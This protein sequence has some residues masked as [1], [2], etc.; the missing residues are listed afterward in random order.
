MESQ[1]ISLNVHPQI[2]DLYEVL[3]KN[4]LHKQKEDVQSLVGY[5]ESMEYNLSV[6]MNEIQE[7]HAEVK[8]LHDRGIR[9]QCG[10]IIS[11][12]EDKI[13]QAKT[14][15]SVI[16]VRL[17]DAAG[18]AVKTCKEK[19][20]SA[21]IRAVEAMRVSTALSKIKSG[22]SHMSQSMRQSAGQIDV[23]RGELHEVGGHMKNAGR[24]LLG[25][26]AKQAGKLRD[27]LESCGDTFSK[28]ERSADRLI[29]KIQQN[30][31]QAKQKQSVKSDLRQLKTQR[32]EKSKAPVLKEQAR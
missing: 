10:K 12:A 3:E 8:R 16:K 21:L 14:M 26:S 24:A 15:V 30:E 19:G 28:M 6:M 18:N 25:R 27:F 31:K 23:I 20:K 1:T 17:I 7:M 29:D 4:G 11:K 22:F 9:N 32:H 2:L 5:V 13:H